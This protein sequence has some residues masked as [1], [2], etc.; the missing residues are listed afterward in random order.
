MTNSLE[1]QLKLEAEL[2]RLAS[3]TADYKEGVKAFQE[4]RAPTFS[5]R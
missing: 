4:K 3:K 2:Q 5:G 1:E